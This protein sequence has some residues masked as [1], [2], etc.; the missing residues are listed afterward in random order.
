MVE[1]SGCSSACTIWRA[2]RSA[3][4]LLLLLLQEKPVTKTQAP[5]LPVQYVEGLSAEPLLPLLQEKA[6]ADIVAM[7]SCF[8]WQEASDQ[9][10]ALPLKLAQAHRYILTVS[11]GL[12]RRLSGT[13]WGFFFLSVI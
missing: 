6:T 3:E 7:L 1:G 4:P 12:L 5:N 2:G 8:V 11:A 13:N 10:P 9:P